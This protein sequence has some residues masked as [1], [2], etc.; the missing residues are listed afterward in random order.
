MVDAARVAGKLASLG[1]YSARLRQLAVMDDGDYLAS[2]AYEGRYLV[3]ASAQV[4]IDLANHLIASSGWAPA[5][6][7]R[8]AFERLR[9]QA[10][11]PADLAARMQDLTGLRNRLVHLYDD[12]DDALVLDGIR[13]GLPDL[14]AFAAAYARVAHG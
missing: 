14:D 9:D 13:R 7:F 4:C 11:L 10:V 2:H 5:A 1:R 12:V 6:E 3:Q 8:Q